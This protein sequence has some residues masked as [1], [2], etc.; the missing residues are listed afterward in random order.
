MII[1]AVTARAVTDNE[2]GT[3]G[4]NGSNGTNPGGTGGPG[5]YA[6]RTDGLVEALSACGGIGSIL[7][8]I[9][10]IP[11]PLRDCGYKLVSRVRYAIFGEWKPRPLARPEWAERFIDRY[12]S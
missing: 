8:W 6:L 5:D 12:P 9:R 4:T 1:P 3:P 7:A 10:F 11:R 2:T